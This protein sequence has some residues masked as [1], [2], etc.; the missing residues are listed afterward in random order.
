MRNFGEI[1][2]EIIPKINTKKKIDFML[3][4]KSDNNE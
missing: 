2:E 4:K 3:G 1:V